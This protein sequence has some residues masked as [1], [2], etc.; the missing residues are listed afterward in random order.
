MDKGEKFL[1]TAIVILLPVFAVIAG[2]LAFSS[3]NFPK[4]PKT[5]SLAESKNDSKGNRM[6]IR[7]VNLKAAR[8]R[9]LSGIT[10][11][12]S[13]YLG[14]SPVFFEAEE[15]DSG[16]WVWSAA[17]YD[18]DNQRKTLIRKSDKGR[19]LSLFGMFGIS[20]DKSKLLLYEQGSRASQTKDAL[21]F[22]D[23]YSGSTTQI[24][25]LK[26]DN[27]ESAL[28][29]AGWSPDSEYVTYCIKSKGK[30]GENSFDLFVYRIKT[31][32]T[33]QYALY[34]S[35]SRFNS[36]SLPRASNDGRYI[37]FIGVQSAEV[38]C[39]YRLDLHNRKK[40]AEWLRDDTH[41]FYL[42]GDG[43]FAVAASAYVK[44]AKKGVFFL[45]TGTKKEKPITNKQFWFDVTADGK[46]I[47][48]LADDD[49]SPEVR[50]ANL[51]NGGIGESVLLYKLSP[52]QEI[53][54]LYWNRDGSEVA[55]AVNDDGPDAK[56]YIIGLG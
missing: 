24:A 20:P 6:N 19:L 54:G 37:Y 4:E 35:K 21:Y 15:Q 51:G 46:S 1:K 41:L 42:S 32:E 56:N 49:G 43:E 18:T 7:E 22:Y 38:S 13:G 26:E 17:V 31:G 40:E 11:R 45:D 39:L 2:V 52:D 5:L 36:I 53:W 48:Y 27:G 10:E 12:V 33:R 28:D 8:I 25:D 9:L 16:N 34:E 44:S 29:G 55:V 30:S 47:I 3:M 50:A 14:D 23:S